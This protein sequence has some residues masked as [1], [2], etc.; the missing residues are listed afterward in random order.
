MSD[1]LTQFWASKLNRWIDQAALTDAHKTEY[2]DYLKKMSEI[3]QNK[4]I[5]LLS[6]D[7]ALNQH[8]KELL[9]FSLTKDK[10]LKE[11]VVEIS[12]TYLN[13]SVA[14]KS[15]NYELAARLRDKERKLREQVKEKIFEKNNFNRVFNAYG[16]QLIWIEPT[17]VKRRTILRVVLHNYHSF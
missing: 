2:R 5:E 14:V 4:E 15:Q 8:G 11:I 12:Q 13:K 6:I 17:D 7:D 3:L 10:G 1:S 9:D 16:N